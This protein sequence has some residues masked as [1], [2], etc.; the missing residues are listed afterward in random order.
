M[1]LKKILFIICGSLSLVFGIL[2][3]LLP[4]LP[5][6]PFLLLTAYCYANGSEKF[7]TWFTN[8]ALY[9]KYLEN[10][11]KNRSMTLKTKLSILLPASIVLLFPLFFLH[12]WYLKLFILCLYF[13]KY[14]YFFTQIETIQE[15][16]K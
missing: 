11:V 15:A 16:T 6:T 9:K 13:G 10:F 12:A 7:H 4:I 14:Y 2:G 1:N 8:T 3:I 5:T